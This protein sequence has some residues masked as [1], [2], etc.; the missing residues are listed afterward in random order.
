VRLAVEASDRRGLYADIATAV[1]ETKTD[2]RSFE[3]R[4]E[5]ARVFGMIEVQ[6]ENLPHLRKTLR[7]IRRVKGVTEVSRREQ[8]SE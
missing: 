2:I 5:D 7:A 1:S 8:T 6:V 4:S 3:L